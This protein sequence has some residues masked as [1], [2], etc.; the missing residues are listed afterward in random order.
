MI[1]ETI[2]HMVE[3]T[4]RRRH[5]KEVKQWKKAAVRLARA[6]IRLENDNYRYYQTDSTVKFA[7]KVI[8]DGKT[9]TRS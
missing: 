4:E 9:A 8:R 2:E 5:S 3:R 6:V 7:Y 1:G